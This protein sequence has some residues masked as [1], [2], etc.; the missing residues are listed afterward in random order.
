MLAVIRVLIVEDSAADAALIESALE[1]AGYD[2]VTS[3]V[4][5]AT[6]LCAALDEATWDAVILSLIHI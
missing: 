3:R 4:D 6:G 5:S 2:L 1:Q